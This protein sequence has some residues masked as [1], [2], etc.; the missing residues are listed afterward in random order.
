MAAGDVTSSYVTCMTLFFFLLIMVH[1]STMG[2]ADSTRERTSNFP[3]AN[4]SRERDGTSHYCT[5]FSTRRPAGRRMMEANYDNR[6]KSTD[7]NHFSPPARRRR[8][9]PSPWREKIFNASAHEVP[10]GPNPISNR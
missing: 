5:E 10:S 8:R 6:S 1:S 4:S 2:M 3:H 9:W 7:A